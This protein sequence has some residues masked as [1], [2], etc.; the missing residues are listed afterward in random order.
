M[1]G[2]INKSIA[3]ALAESNLFGSLPTEVRKDI[4]ATAQEM[5]LP[6]G[7][8]FGRAGDRGTSCGLVVSGKVHLF[9]TGKGGTEIEIVRLGPGESFGEVC[10][11]S[12]EPIP[13]S[14]RTIEDT[15][16]IFFPRE[17]FTEV[18]QKYPEVAAG[19]GKGVSRWM[20]R[21]SSGIESRVSR[22]LAPS[23]LKWFDFVPIVV[24]SLLCTVAYNL[25][26]PK[27]LPFLPKRIATEAG[28]FI[29]ATAAYQKFKQGGILFIDALPAELHEEG[30]IPSAVNLPLA[31]FDFMYDMKLDKLDKNQEVIVYGRTISK[32]Y[33]EEVAEKLLVRGFENVKILDG[34]LADWKKNKY[35]V[36]S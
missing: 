22:Q 34:G 4:A 5:T 33:D 10:L 2:T 6:A 28:S 23:G 24:L 12:D 7:T 3:E 36:T 27:G 19:V 1:P 18:I 8:V 13:A 26:N 17:S 15:R 21:I 11:L 29:S 9:R 32:Y 30:H 35:P 14:V 31:I 20:H 25:S 16:L